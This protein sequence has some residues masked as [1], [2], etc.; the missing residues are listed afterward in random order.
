ME[1]TIP[2]EQEKAIAKL[3]T[4][5]LERREAFITALAR[6]TPAY[7]MHS[8]AEE[9]S[10]ELHAPTNEIHEVLMTLAGMY[11]FAVS[12]GMKPSEF[13]SGIVTAAKRI[14]PKITPINNDWVSFASFLERVLSLER[15]LGVTAKAAE[16]KLEQ[17]RVYSDARV[18][19]D[20]RP[21]FANDPAAPPLSAVL[22]HNLRI[23][24]V[25][26]NDTQEF[27]VALDE[28]DLDDLIRTLQRAKAK[29]KTLKSFAERT[30]LKCLDLPPE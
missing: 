26:E 29:E 14:E 20:L 18:M 5:P 1:L 11:T 17:E 6:S 12:K 9:V 16:V 8:L 7:L 10:R 3:A 21:I 13:A 4:T 25:T 2:K 15:T 24:F 19:T 23:A 22:I 30:G 27:F 28:R